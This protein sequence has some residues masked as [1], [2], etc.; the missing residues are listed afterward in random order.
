[1][2]NTLNKSLNESLDKSWQKFFKKYKS[3]IDN[4]LQLYD[5][6]TVYPKKEDIF[7]IF[8]SIKLNEIK[9]II[10][11]QDC[12]IN[13]ENGIPQ[14]TGCAFSVPKTHKIPPSLKNI[15]KELDETIDDFN[16]PNHGDLTKWIKQGVF[17]LNCSLTV[18]KGK[19]NSHYKYWKKITD[20]LINYIS[21]KR[22][23]IVFILWGNFSR[24][25]KKLINGNHHIIEGIHPSPLSA[26]YNLKGTDKSFFGNN[27]FNKTN[28]YLESKNINLINWNL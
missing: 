27:Y 17:L 6:E 10:L 19:S 24:D 5:T 3:D 14:A 28:N 21:E 9:V 12:Y 23:N 15:Y 13:E 2:T 18:E 8:K 1:M 7:S 22:E 20:N 4:I 25:K 16:I 26:R 11:G